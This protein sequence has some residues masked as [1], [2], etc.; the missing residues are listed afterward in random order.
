MQSIPENAHIINQGGMPRHFR[1]ALAVKAESPAPGSPD[2]FQDGSVL[3]HADDPEEALDL[4]LQTVE[5]LVS[6]GCP[7]HD[8]PVESPPG[9]VSS[10][11]TPYVSLLAGIVAR[12][13]RTCGH[14]PPEP[15][16]A[17]DHEP[18]CSYPTPRGLGR[19]VTATQHAEC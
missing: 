10:E 2:A 14:P 19:R 15:D 4:I 6:L 18:D 1:P 16:F 13:S 12:Q 9:C 3:L 11:L 7:S 5:E 8:I 17:A